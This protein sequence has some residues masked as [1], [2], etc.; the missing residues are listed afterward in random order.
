MAAES[1]VGARLFLIGKSGVLAGLKEIQA[2]TARLNA[3]IAAGADSSKI[4][5]AGYAEQMKG[6]DALQARMDLYQTNLAAVGAET[7]AVARLGKVAFFSLAAAGAAWG[8]E[9]VKWASQYQTAL[10]R[11]RTQAG[12]TASAVGSIG[13]AARANAAAL[14]IGPATYLKAAYHPASTGMGTRETI[15]IT[16]A[17]TKL[18][19]IGRPTNPQVETTVNALTGVMKSYRS[20]SALKSASVLNAIIGAGNMTVST[21][22]AAL[23][24]GIASVSRT[25]GV[26]L[27]A[28][29][30][31]LGYLTD[32]GVPAAMAG[33]HLRMFET[34]VG[35]P[36]TKS[37]SLLKLAGFTTKTITSSGN[38]LSQTLQESGVNASALSRAL[39]T[40]KGAGGI[41][42]ALHLLQMGL[43]RQGLT[44]QMTADLLAR[45]F[46]GG[47]MGTTAMQLFGTL[48]TLRAKSTKIAKTGTTSRFNQDWIKTTQLLDF[49]MHQ[50]RATVKTLG[51]TFGQELIP[52][53]TKAIG[54]FT[55][56][57]KWADK[58]KEVVL[59]LAGAVSLVLVPAIGVYLYRALLSSGGAIRTVIQGYANLISGQTAEQLALARTDGALG[60]TTGETYQLVAANRALGGA[61]D[62]TAGQIAVEDTALAGGAGAKGATAAFLAGRGGYAIGAGATVAGIYGLG[63]IAD[64][65]F[66]KMVVP[67]YRTRSKILSQIAR[68]KKTITKQKHPGTG[69]GGVESWGP[70]GAAGRWFTAEHIPVLQDNTAGAVA[71]DQAQIKGYQQDLQLWDQIHRLDPGAV[72]S[73]TPI[74]VKNY[75]YLDG[76][77]IAESNA[78]QTRKIAARTTSS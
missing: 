61:A 52:P 78:K 2:A 58:N 41:Y 56:L 10:T 60:Q 43:A 70:F 74:I 20:R 71:R 29:G 53:L 64:N 28:M 37:A 1:N 21:L 51:T 31:A 40:N 18:A 34:L 16:N 4:A 57:L 72:T 42:N 7:D 39:R 11:L 3:E 5:A 6:L 66:S 63:K 46:G 65:D 35:A 44:K 45:L 15:A 50:L 73:K 14:G 26:S 76:K 32:R 48:H 23:A 36:T 62:T 47:R 54:L 68:L 25:Y 59:G 55:D 67:F 17:G 22:N 30:G 49:Q 13:R 33:T 12:L 19:N 9:S 8:Y 27:G 75:V 24:S 69:L 77:R 38:A